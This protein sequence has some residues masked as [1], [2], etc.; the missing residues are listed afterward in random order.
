MFHSFCIG[1]TCTGFRNVRPSGSESALK[2]A[3][4]NVGPISVAVDA[5]QYSFKHY[6]SGVYVEPKCTRRATHAVLVIGYGTE[7][8][9]DYWLIKNR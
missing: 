4:A 2:A 7:G 3:V 9:L 1:A 8:G 6:R 5:K